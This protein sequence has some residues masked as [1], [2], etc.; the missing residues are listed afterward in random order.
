MT[1]EQFI[2]YIEA[3]NKK[4]GQYT[5]E[6]IIDIG[7]KHYNLLNKDKNWQKLAEMLGYVNNLG[8]ISG[9]SLRKF[10]YRN[11]D[12]ND[13]HSE[14]IIK[15]R[16]LKK[17]QIKNRDIL[18][19]YNRHI[20]TEARIEAFKDDILNAI[21]N[22]IKLPDVNYIPTKNLLTE[23][24]AI[25]P[26]ADLH[27]GLEF[28]NYYNAYSKEISEQRVKTLLN[29]VVQYCEQNKVSRLHFLNMGDLIS[30]LIHI[31]L[32]V[33]QNQDV[34]TQLIFAS[35]L[36]ANFL[37][38]LSAYVPTITY[39]S[40]VDNH[41]RMIANKNEHIELENLNRIIDWFL[42]E[43]LKNNKRII[44]P[45]DNIDISIGKFRLK[46]NKL[47]MFVHGHNDSK[48][49]VIQNLIGLT[50]EYVD[51]VFM[52]HYHNSSEHT[53]QD[54]KL[55]ISGSIIGTD[56]YAFNKRLFGKPEQNLFIFD[57]D[58]CI[59]KYDIYL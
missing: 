56:S 16:E 7:L 55:F 25:L 22:M 5:T 30:G 39:R 42:E 2:T 15:L 6:E 31:S 11:L 41:S 18:N 43:R 26:F 32:R 9:E 49:S 52:A 27:L 59:I 1:K 40:V 8:R 38:S 10:I 51:Y 28:K 45:K 36:I 29:R 17:E 19:N 35:E 13:L 12:I 44:F 50:K 24:E 3:F 57:K 47:V 20:R 14:Q 21:N 48:R 37:N 46:N 58:N 4:V 34:V 53:F 23:T 54:S 33:E